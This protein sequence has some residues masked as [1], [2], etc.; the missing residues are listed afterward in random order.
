[1]SEKNRRFT[2]VYDIL[3][4]SE[5]V[6]LDFAAFDHMIA[7]NGVPFVHFKSILCPISVVDRFDIRSDHLD[8]RCD[9]GFL[10]ELA[11]GLTAFFSGNSTSTAFQNAGLIDGSSIQVTLPRVYDDSNK[12]VVASE[13]DRFYLKDHVGFASHQQRFESHQSGTERLEFPV[14]HVEYLIDARGEYYKQDVDFILQD[15]FVKWTGQR[16]PGYDAVA[17]KGVVCSIR[18]QYQPFWYVSRIMHEI[19]VVREID[20]LTGEG[21]TV[22]MP[23]AVM[24]QRE[25]VFR[26]R[27]KTSPTDNNPRGA[28]G[29]EDGAFG[30]R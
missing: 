2:S 9:N 16:R 26:S 21:S 22:R 30:P 12:E 27:T 5:G 7:Q 6:S 15:G 20:M 19:R 24:L 3:L 1:M 25:L 13:Y 18:Y 14:E 29:P 4:P 8:C 11:G 10:Y 23:F 17:H 28:N